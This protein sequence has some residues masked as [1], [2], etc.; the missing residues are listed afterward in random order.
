[1]DFE[2]ELPDRLRSCV[3]TLQPDLTGL[4]TDT[5]VLGERVVRRRRFVQV[6]GVGG[7]TLALLGGGVYLAAAQGMPGPSSPVTS[8]SLEV[9]GPAAGQPEQTLI[10]A[11]ASLQVLLD[12]LPAGAHT[13]DYQGASVL[14]DK[15][16]AASGDF[17]SRV[18]TFA[19]LSYTDTDG[20]SMIW[21][22]LAWGDSA[23]D[24]QTDCQ[25]TTP[26]DTCEAKTLP[27]GSALVLRKTR[28]YAS[29]PGTGEGRGAKVWEAWL[30]RADGLRIQ[31]S[32]NN[33]TAREG[34][35]ESRPAP[36]LS[37]GQ[38]EAIIT[39]PVWQT[40]LSAAEVKRAE[41]LFT[42]QEEQ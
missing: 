20:A 18:G 28:T 15:Q 25:D 39:N 3:R 16:A 31:I 33:S 4:V 37:L 27:D 13:G 30:S 6:L 2:K 14:S 21:V 7:A 23:P 12:Q 10:T 8:Q 32:E 29:D 19:Q 1:M 41:K 40:R 22:R 9:A 42:P 35:P 24:L 36:P 34:A 38:L 11:Q 5:V 17:S 26:G